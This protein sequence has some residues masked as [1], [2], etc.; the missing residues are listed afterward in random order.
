MLP[1]HRIRRFQPTGRVRGAA[2]HV[3]RSTSGMIERSLSRSPHLANLT[4]AAALLV[5]SFAAAPATTQDQQKDEQDKAKQDK[6][7][8]G[9]LRR[10]RN[11]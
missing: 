4:R 3:Q 11:P 5:A 10:D 6:T 7:A 1:E 8:A 9:A 2:V